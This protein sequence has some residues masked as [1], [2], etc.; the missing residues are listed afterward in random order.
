MDLRFWIFPGCTPRMKKNEARDVSRIEVTA[1]ILADEQG[2]VLIA[3]RL[4]GG[5]AGGRWEFPGGKIEAGESAEQCLVR[6]LREE[7]GI[8]TRVTSFFGES[9]HDYPGRA[10]RLKAFRVEKFRGE[11]R[12]VAHDL[13]L[14]VPP[15]EM[16]AFDFLEADRPLVRRLQEEK[17]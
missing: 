6:E 2:R 17:F 1:A 16:D 11:I 12:P 5:S 10:I 4:P 14:F 8:E 13:V 7:L 3:R 15:D 9:S